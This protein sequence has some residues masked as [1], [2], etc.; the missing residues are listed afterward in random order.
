MILNI[1]L[2]SIK[3]REDDKNRV[4]GVY[5]VI[6]N[7]GIIS[8][9]SSRDSFVRFDGIVI[10]G[11]EKT[12]NRNNSLLAIYTAFFDAL[13]V[14]ESYDI[15]KNSIVIVKNKD[16]KILELLRNDY[17][18]ENVDIQQMW[19]SIKKLLI[20][21]RDIRYE[22]ISDQSYSDILIGAEKWL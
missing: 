18:G 14:L 16:N 1:F 7:P 3:G 5:R 10:P 21:Y 6:P 20:K 22:L 15:T 17:R 8:K 2:V 11:N 9:K 13:Q 19:P 4:Y 12:K